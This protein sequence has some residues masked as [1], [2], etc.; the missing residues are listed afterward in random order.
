M[1][2]IKRTTT[3]ALKAAERAEATAKKWDDKA[4]AARAEA[5]QMDASAGAAILAD[6]SQAEK[7]TLTLQAQERKAR[8]YDSAAAEARREAAQAR[9]D[10]LRIEADELDRKAG[11]LEK[12][13]DRLAQEVA[14]AL[15]DLE[16]LNGVPY[17]RAA[18]V[19]PHEAA[20]GVGNAG[21]SNLEWKRREIEDVRL[22]ADNIRHYLATGKTANDKSDLNTLLDRDYSLMVMPIT[23]QAVHT[24]DLLRSMVNS[25]QPLTVDLVS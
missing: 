23:L 12:D 16:R 1:G 13:A 20:D 14:A 15:A 25:G 10:A 17:A 18:A 3:D 5:Q 11:Q 6:E 2:I 21:L 9:A 22:A 19:L 4:A 8:A 7:I 24:T